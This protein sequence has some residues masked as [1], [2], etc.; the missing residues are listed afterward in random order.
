[1]KHLKKTFDEVKFYGYFSLVIIALV[2]YMI[3]WADL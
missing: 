3:I 1:M 2:I